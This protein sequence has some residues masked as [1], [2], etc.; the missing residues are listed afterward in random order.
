MK[1]SNLI[2]A[3]EP[4]LIGGSDRGP[5]PLAVDHDITSIHYRSN[6]VK[7]GGLFVAL[8]GQR[9]D[10]HDFVSEAVSRGAAA[11]VVQD[12]EGSGA[13]SGVIRVLD[14]RK[15]LA[16][17]AARF[18]GEPSKG[19][20]LIGI[21]GTNGK[22]TTAFLLE[23][24]LS[25]LGIRVGVIGTIDCRYAGR[26]YANPLTTP[27][28]LN[29]QEI[30]SKMAASG[31]THVIM[32]VSSHGVALERIFGCEFDVGVFTNLSQ[33]HLDFH[34]SMEAYWAAKK[35]F[36][37]DHLSAGSKQARAVAVINRDD[38][39]G[40]ELFKILENMS[41]I[42]IGA[43]S[44][45]MLRPVHVAV[46]QYGIKAGI[47]TADEECAFQSG[48]IGL[49]NLENI[50]CAAGAGVALG[51]PLPNI[52]SGISFFS[53]VPGRLEPVLNGLKRQVYVDYAHTPDALAK[54][55]QA[56]RRVLTGRLICVF[57][58]GGDRDK[59]KRPR[60]GEIA[61]RLSDL[62]VIT[63]DNPRTEPPEAIIADIVK[64]VESMMDRRY[65]PEELDRGFEEK[66]FIVE[67]D[68]ERAI[69]LGIKLSAEGDTILIAGKGH[70]T[71]QIISGKTIR[72]DDREKAAEAVAFI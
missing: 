53:H 38:S 52:C 1:L 4:F 28:S 62:V 13:G 57:G 59:T 26:S 60:M 63:S 33:D 18:Y 5:A 34:G 70:E 51:I 64:G 27:E 2:A 43:D 69:F 10:G 17:I 23:H 29:L 40:R 37:T 36:F 30:L 72:F 47:Q 61:A 22:T 8:K 14:T 67:P 49:Y 56:L 16:K 9:A 24:M 21:T 6:D 66:G 55:L 12:R 20:V 19:L 45:A 42:T 58:C 71:Y 25:K 41:R 7:P 15:V 50:L 65:F 68:R 31:V 11:V 39:K 46:D 54:V 32:E 35:R 48:L 44:D 3:I